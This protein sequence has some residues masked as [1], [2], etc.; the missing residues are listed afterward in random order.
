LVRKAKDK[1]VAKAIA[2][3]KKDPE[4]NEQD[5]NDLF[6]D[7]AQYNPLKLN[8]FSVAADGV[9]FYYDYGFP[10]VIQALQPAGEFKFTWKQL[11]PYIKP[12]GLLARFAR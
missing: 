8:D 2:D 5:P 6:K 7:S 1:E 9:S 11:K 3:I 12:G 4:F 10:H